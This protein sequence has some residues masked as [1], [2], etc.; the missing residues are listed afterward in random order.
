[1][2]FGEACEAARGHLAEGA[3]QKDDDYNDH[4]ESLPAGLN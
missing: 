3:K 1:V 2:K 4:D